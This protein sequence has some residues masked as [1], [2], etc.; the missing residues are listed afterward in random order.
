MIEHI[1]LMKTK[2]RLSNEVLYRAAEGLKSMD[3]NIERVIKVLVGTNTSPG[4]KD[5]GYDFGLVVRF[6]IA[7]DRDDYWVHPYHR[8][9]EKEH[10]SKYMKQVIVFDLE[11]KDEEL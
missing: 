10:I 1:V 11:Y 7:A 2:D 5:L 8:K 9:M 3:K 4:H 6:K